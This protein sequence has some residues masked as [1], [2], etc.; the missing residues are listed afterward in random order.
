MWGGRYGG[1]G[2][3]EGVEEVAGEAGGED[4]DF[5]G[6]LGGVGGSFSMCFGG[7]GGVAGGAGERFSV[8]STRFGGEM[9]GIRGEGGRERGDFFVW[10]AWICAWSWVFDEKILGQRLHSYGFWR[11]N[12]V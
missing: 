3:D 9:V 1:G 10:W 7:G 12:A 4:V 6:V 5:I 11:W 2:G 8:F